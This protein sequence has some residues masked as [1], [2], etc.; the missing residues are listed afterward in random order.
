MHKVNYKRRIEKIQQ[1]VDSQEVEALLIEQKSDL[2]YLLGLDLS[3]GSLII[4]PSEAHLFVDG[5]YYQACLEKNPC[6]VTLSTDT[7]LKDYL[8]LKRITQLA[9][10]AENTSYQ[11]FLKL[12]TIVP[13]LVSINGPLKRIRAIKEPCEIAL[14]RAAASLGC[15]GYDFVVSQLKEG[16]NEIDLARALEIFWLQKG[17]EGLAF[18]PIIAFGPNSALPHYRAGNSSLQ[19][20][21]PVLID[22]GVTLQHYHSDMTRV[23]FF[24]EPLTQLLE[25]YEIVQ[26][27]QQAALDHCQPGTTTGELDLIA[28]DLISRHGYGAHFTHSLGH[29]VG[30]DIH[31]YP[32]LRYR[33]DVEPVLL[34]AGMVITIEPGIYLPGVG[35]VRIEDTVVITENGYEN[36]TDRS[37][38]KKVLLA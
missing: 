21:Q 23:L 10:D 18:S 27:A 32:T 3:A 1:A 28:R 33:P 17:G 16:I 35:G 36:L 6:A 22:I 38:E 19:K 9:F 34:E 8:K 30:L 31:E 14:L 20:K 13:T 4:T 2:Y 37:K 24:G 5:R 15:C 29:G 26:Q 12:E 11:R 7:A 25:I